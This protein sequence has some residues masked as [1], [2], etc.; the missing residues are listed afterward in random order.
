MKPTYKLTDTLK[1]LMPFLTDTPEHASV[2]VCRAGVGIGRGMLTLG[3]A[4]N[5]GLV[6]VTHKGFRSKGGK[7]LTLYSRISSTPYIPKQTSDF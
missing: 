7:V 2:I 5:V 6:Q 1:L 3:W 4:G